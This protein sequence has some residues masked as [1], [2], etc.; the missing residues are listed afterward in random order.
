[1]KNNGSIRVLEKIYQTNET[2]YEKLCSMETSFFANMKEPF[3]RYKR[4]EIGNDARSAGESS[5]EFFKDVLGFDEGKSKVAAGYLGLYM[6][7]AAIQTSA[8]TNKPSRAFKERR[9]EYTEKALEDTAGVES[10]DVL[11]PAELQLQMIAT[12]L[13]EY[14]GPERPASEDY[15]WNKILDCLKDNYYDAKAIAT[16]LAAKAEAEAPAHPVNPFAIDGEEPP[17]LKPPTEG[18]P[19][20]GA[21]M[22]PGYHAEEELRV[23]TSGVGSKRKK[24]PSISP[25]ADDGPGEDTTS[26]AP[27]DTAEQPAAKRPASTAATS[28][29]GGTLKR[30]HQCPDCRRALADRRKRRTRRKRRHGEPKVT[31]EI[32]AL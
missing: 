7:P 28:A 26:R 32:V 20:E 4:D 10:R 24:R 25:D 15:L 13:D 31:V 6:F 23:S 1:M 16:G 9:V 14:P 21:Y 27:G 12:Y 8:K 19:T 29:F 18:A 11:P 2:A 3:F 17:L 30:S 22:D 5:I